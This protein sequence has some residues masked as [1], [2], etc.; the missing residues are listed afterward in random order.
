M[1]GMSG[2]LGEIDAEQVAQSRLR[3]PLGLSD[4]TSKAAKAVLDL[5]AAYLVGVSREALVLAGAVSAATG[6]PV[7]RAEACPEGPVVLLESVLVTGAGV[8]GA[9]NA[10]PSDLGPVIVVAAAGRGEVPLW[11]ETAVDKILVLDPLP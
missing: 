4:A 6:V 1:G 2:L 10:L 7:V 8:A 9:L 5:G 3:S 11:L